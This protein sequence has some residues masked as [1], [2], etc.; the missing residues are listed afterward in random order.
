MKLRGIS[1][2][3]DEERG[4]CWKLRWRWMKE[5]VGCIVQI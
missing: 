4:C 1:I 5:E 3:E 2:H